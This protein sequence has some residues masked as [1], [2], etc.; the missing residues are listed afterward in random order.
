[1]AHAQI[2]FTTVPEPAVQV[3]RLQQRSVDLQDEHKVARQSFQNR[4]QQLH[5]SWQDCFDRHQHSWSKE[6]A[7]AEVCMTLHTQTEN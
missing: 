2:R 5:E 1:M 3:E 6:K 7:Q 4:L